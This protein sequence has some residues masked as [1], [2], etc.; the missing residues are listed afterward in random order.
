MKRKMLFC[1]A[2]LLV[3]GLLLSGCGTSNDATITDESSVEQEES[4]EASQEESQEVS[5]EASSEASTAA[6]PEASSDPSPAASPE[7][8]TTAKPEASPAASPSAGQE[9]TAKSGDDVSAIFAKAA[10]ISSMSFDFIVT[11]DE[12]KMT[13]KACV[14][15][16]RMKTEMTVEGEKMIYIYDSK[17]GDVITYF[18][19]Q[20]MAMKTNFSKEMGGLIQSPADYSDNAASEDIKTVGKETI[21]GLSCIVLNIV[22]KENKEEYKMWVSEKYGIPV[23]VES[24]DENG[25]SVIEY[26]NIKVGSVQ[27]SEFE[28]PKGVEITSM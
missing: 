11:S 5:Q 27:D 19:E 13:G 7:A 15:G 4:Q 23:R 22:D 2:V 6:S 3:A 14:K 25:K 12:G 24:T 17:S 26:K 10:T 28:L 20:N 18:P 1:L 16:T 9:A 8:P 21:D